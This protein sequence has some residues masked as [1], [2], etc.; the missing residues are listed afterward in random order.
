MENQHRPRVYSIPAHRGFAEA[1]VA[2]LIPRYGADPLGLARLTLLLPSQRAARSITEAFVRMVGESGGLLLPRMVVVGDLDLDEALGSLLDPLGAREVPPSAEPTRRWLRLAALIR[3]IEGDEAPKGAALLRRAW[4]AGQ[5]MDRLAVEGIAPEAL[6]SDEIVALVGEQA[7]H[8]RD[9]TRS[10]LM[11]MAHWRA[12][13]DS[14]E[15]VDAPTRRNLLFDHAAR[16]WRADPPRHPIVVAGVTSAS[17][18]LAGLL[19]VVSE[20]PEGAV[21][22]P[23][24]DLSL[25]AQVWD[26]LGQA[27]QPLEPGGAPFGR[28]DAGTH[29]QYHLKLLLHRM[30]V[31]RGEVQLWHRSGTSAAPP[32]RARAISNLFLPPAASA[33]WVDLPERQRRLAAVRLMESDHPGEEAQAIALLIRQALETPERRVALVTP[34]RGLASRV[35]AHLARWGIGAD[36]SGGQPL[37]Q[38]VAG[39]FL[40]L[41]A[42]VA[43]ERAPPVPLIA[44][45]GHPLV[46]AGEGRPRWL[47]HLRALDL[48][49][50]GPRPDAG[51]EPLAERIAQKAPRRRA[52]AMK[53][54]WGEVEAALAPLLDATR[55]ESAPLTALLDALVTC[56]EALCG[57]GLWGQADGRALS[58]FVDGLRGAAE[59]A[60]LAIP[61]RDLPAMLRDAMDRVSVRPPWGG[62]PRV[63]IYGLLEARMAR[64]DLIVCGG[65][66]EGVWPGAP[67]P[68]PLLPPAVLRQ[69]GVP[70]ADF[71]IGLAAHDLAACLGAPEVVLSWALRDEGAPVIPSRFVLRVM[72]ML[73]EKLAKD[74]RETQAVEWA[75]SLDLGRQVP[76][77]PRPQPFPSSDQ[78]RVDIPVTALDR[79]R[80]DPYQFYAQA[81]L[82]LRAIDALDA[83]PSPAWRGTAVHA[84]LD[85]WH[86]QGAQPGT[87][88]A[89]AGV[90]LDTMSAHPLERSLWRPRLI[91]AL[92]WIDAEVLELTQTGRKVLATE[93]KGEMKVDGIRIHG[94]ADR[95]DR[96]PD[97]TLAVVDY[98][99]G[100]PPS[101]K[102]VQA[103]FALQLGLIGMIA[104]AGGF[105]G[106][107][108]EAT[109]FEYWSLSRARKGG[110]FGWRDEPILEKPKRSGIPR[111]DFIPE[112]E[113]FLR[114]AIARWLL[115]SEPFT[116]RLNPDIAG[117][118]DYDQLMRLDEWIGALGDEDKS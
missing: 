87:L 26:E 9:A 43:G 14:L 64:A 65:L 36:D 21:V 90:V 8:W 74:H 92:E 98:K 35:V 24:L 42:E 53:L 34:D 108:G 23:D 88:A 27:G 48:M 85:A 19:R 97:G 33:R 80:A 70:G 6:L 17:P 115:G 111:E 118:N 103:G 67:K 95:I 102:Q 93:I 41:L 107:G 78:R 99:T 25:D 62:H 49:L 11:L 10:F 72:A 84:I 4:E 81:I 68:D 38:T 63:A 18:S 30:G 16:Q 76:P 47:E 56:G 89:T 3:Q 51:L 59:G 1:L 37:S 82:N 101:G 71:R 83:V 45:L 7:G 66:T 44:M 114:E 2:G 105:E 73:G 5:T 28:E 104:Q 61:P 40:L 86:K 22:L 15:Q 31:A 112:T 52:E 60:D 13:L 50:R 46:A 113:K 75:R 117:Y 57:E 58:L 29:P 109:R 79:L 39:R 20:L 100:A 32:E 94:R 12:E 69:L 77:H 116:A 110:G 106:I 91:A 54:W 55:E 96:N